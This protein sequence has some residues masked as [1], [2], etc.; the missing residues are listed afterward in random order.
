[1]IHD[2][3]SQ[4]GKKLLGYIEF[5]DQEQL[6]YETHRHPIGA[7]LIYSG[8][9]AFSVFVVVLTLVLGGLAAN[10]GQEMGMSTDLQPLILVFG[11]ILAVFGIVASLISGFLYQSNIML[12]TSDKVAQVLRPGLFNHKISQLSLGDIQ[13]VTV[14]K[15]GILANIFDFGTVVV[16]TAGE[17]ESYHFTFAPRPYE[18]AKAIVSAHEKNLKQYG[19]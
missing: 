16:E 17:Q 15:Q 9:V 8:G 3:L 6:L 12:V 10:S 11:L 1:M 19:N 2:D 5:D 14:T 18:C 13:D 4:K 7:L